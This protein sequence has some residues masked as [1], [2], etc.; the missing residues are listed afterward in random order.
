[1]LKRFPIKRPGSVNR[2]FRPDGARLGLAAVCFRSADARLR[3][4]GSATEFAI[5]APVFFLMVI[6]FIE[7]GRALMVQQVL[8]MRRVLEH[9]MASTTGSTAPM[10]NQPCK[11][12]RLA[13]PLTAFPLRCR[14]IRPQQPLARR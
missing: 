7:F 9:G 8:S 5:V 10:C 11:I 1:M 13:Y 4:S 14:P 3:R 6:G 12:T 2:A